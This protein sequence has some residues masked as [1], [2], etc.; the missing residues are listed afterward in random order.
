MKALLERVQ[1]VA[2]HPIDAI[3]QYVDQGKKAMVPAILSKIMDRQ[4]M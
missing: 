4:T 2:D 3:N 1:T